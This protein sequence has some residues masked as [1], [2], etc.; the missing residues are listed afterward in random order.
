[1]P[2]A[3]ELCQFGELFPEPVVERRDPQTLSGENPIDRSVLEAELEEG[4]N[5]DVD[6]LLQNLRTTRRGAA[7]G[8]LGMIAEHLKPFLADSVCTRLFGDGGTV[9]EGFDC[10][11]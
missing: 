8:P 2:R 10:R 3:F 4:L 7:A 5:L 6:V 11:P 9:R 1:M